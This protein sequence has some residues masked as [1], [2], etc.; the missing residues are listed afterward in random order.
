[1]KTHIATPVKWHVLRS[2][3]LTLTLLFLSGDSKVIYSA[4]AIT[5]F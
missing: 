1:V 5:K 3:S 2:N 4:Y